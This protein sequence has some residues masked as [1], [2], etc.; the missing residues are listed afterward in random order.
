MDDARIAIFQFVNVRD[1][2]FDIFMNLVEHISEVVTMEGEI[3]FK[4][5]NHFLTGLNEDCRYLVGKIYLVDYRSSRLLSYHW[6]ILKSHE[7]L[8]A[9]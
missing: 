6:H 7:P 8:N 4:F 2:F 5:L 3:L 1:G 9:A